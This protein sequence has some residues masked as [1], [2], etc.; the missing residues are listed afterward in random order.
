MR[1]FRIGHLLPLIAFGALCLVGA[2]PSTVEVDRRPCFKTAMTQYALDECAGEEARRAD[3]Q[4]NDIFGKILLLAKRYPVAVKNLRA[5]DSAWRA[6]RKAY[7]AAMF[8]LP[9]SQ[10]GT[11]LP[12][13]MA[14]QY[15][16][17]TQRH[18]AEM[19][20]ML[21]VYK[22]PSYLICDDSC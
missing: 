10:T 9:R 12:M 6:Y 7:V 8:P 17:V 3:A 14:E 5:T 20:L 13:Q 19:T 21:K 15:A 22:N 1:C 2:A 4:L 16:W 11:I 18:I